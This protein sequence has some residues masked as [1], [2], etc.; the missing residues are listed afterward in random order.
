MRDQIDDDYEIVNGKPVL[1]DGRCIGW[2]TYLTD[3]QRE[4]ADHQPG[5][6]TSVDHAALDRAEA[7]WH[8]S[9]RRTAEASKSDAGR[10]ADAKAAIEIGRDATDADPRAAAT[11]WCGACRRCGAR[12]THCHDSVAGL[13]VAAPL[14]P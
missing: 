6:R 14:T 3:A 9:N 11:R 8:E 10:E 1:K 5:Y 13:H 12:R 2:P 7:A 4:I